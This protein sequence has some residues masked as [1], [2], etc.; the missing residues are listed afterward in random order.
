[1]GSK[2]I[3]ISICDENRK[4]ATPFETIEFINIKKFIL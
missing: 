2:R 1:M 3:G 4:I